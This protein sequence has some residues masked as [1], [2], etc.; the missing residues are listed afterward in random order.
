MIHFNYKNHKYTIISWYSN[1]RMM[2]IKKDTGT[3]A[4][5]I[6]YPS[7]LTVKEFL[8]RLEKVNFCENM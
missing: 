7:V 3:I 2:E 5:T 6:I 4:R 8:S 1:I